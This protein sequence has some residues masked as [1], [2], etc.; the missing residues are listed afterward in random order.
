MLDR[1][2]SSARAEKARGKVGRGQKS[3]RS[4]RGEE[5]RR[6]REGKKETT[7]NPLLKNLRGHWRPQDSDCQ[8]WL[9]RKQVS[10]HVGISSFLI[11]T[12]ACSFENVLKLKPQQYSACLISKIFRRKSCTSCSQSEIY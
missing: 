3:E 12:I 11:V 9:F 5:R 1:R 7:D 8:F 4:E 6:E 2:E 10:R